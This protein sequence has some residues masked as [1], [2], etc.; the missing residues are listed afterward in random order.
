MNLIIR[1]ATPEDA[2]KIAGFNV[3]LARETEQCAI[4]RRL[5][6]AGVRTLLAEPRHG[7]YIVAA[8]GKKIVGMALI[9]FEWSEWQNRQ[10]WW[11]R[12][13]YVDTALR[14]QGV[15]SK[16]YGYIQEMAERQGNVAG[17]RLYVEKE[18]SAA[19]RSYC[20]LG[21]QPNA[22]RFLESPLPVKKAV[23]K[24]IIRRSRKS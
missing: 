3:A 2:S 7:F 9:T 19:L 14:R 5:V 10:W 4:N 22:Y 8:T 20:K 16:I 15:F 11:L 17:I 1:P 12:S 24:K 6:G 23:S 13:V 18:N 21:L